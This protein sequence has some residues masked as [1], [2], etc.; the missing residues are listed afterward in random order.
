MKDYS[1]NKVMTIIMWVTVVLITV[2]LIVAIIIGA[3]KAGK[4]NQPVEPTDTIDPAENVTEPE[5]PGTDIPEILPGT[6][7]D[8][9]NPELST[10]P[11]IIS[12]DILEK[13][14]GNEKDDQPH[15]QGEPSII[16][17]VKEAEDEANG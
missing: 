12:I 10:A 4:S 7:H 13:N 14:K 3:V 8:E 15:I 17:G 11:G 9:S 5:E 16:P 1:K 2:G 6:N